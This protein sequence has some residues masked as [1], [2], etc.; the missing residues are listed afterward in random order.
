MDTNELSRADDFRAALLYLFVPAMVA[1]F[2][3]CFLFFGTAEVAFV[4][5]LATGFAF[6]R[7]HLRV[8]RDERAAGWPAPGPNDPRTSASRRA[9]H[10]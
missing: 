3:L 8:E 2:G 6:Y 5:W 1:V 7:L 4:A 10:R 9:R